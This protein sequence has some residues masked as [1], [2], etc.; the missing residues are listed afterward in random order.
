[1]LF[2]KIKEGAFCQD[3]FIHKILFQEEGTIKL[4]KILQKFGHVFKFII[5]F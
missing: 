5:A 4:S 3:S 1:M 2:D